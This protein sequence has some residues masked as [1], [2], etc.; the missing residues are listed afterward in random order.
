L[1]LPRYTHARRFVHGYLSR[2]AHNSGA[3]FR[4]PDRAGVAYGFVDW[5]QLNR[6]RDVFGFT[7][8][9]WSALPRAA[10]LSLLFIDSRARNQ[11]HANQPESEYNQSRN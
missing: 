10:G 3:D 6:A 8:N 1:L 4:Y 2:Y 7:L 5:L 11:K 9:V